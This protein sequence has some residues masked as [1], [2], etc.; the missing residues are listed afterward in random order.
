MFLLDFL[1]NVQI[2]SPVKGSF[3]NALAIS[4]SNSGKLLSEVLLKL[5]AGLS[6]LLYIIDGN[7]AELPY[8]VGELF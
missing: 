4:M 6:F 1:Q 3:D 5:S 7:H 2:H 8:V